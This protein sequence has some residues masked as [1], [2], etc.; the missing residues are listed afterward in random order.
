MKKKSWVV[1]LVAFVCTFL[2]WGCKHNVAVE[3]VFF[4][5]PSNDGV[6]LLVG[7]TYTPEVYFSPLYPT[8]RGY[9]II[10]GDESVVAVRNNSLT[11]LTQGK[12]YIKVVSDEN[13][14]PQK[15]Q[16]KIKNKN[17]D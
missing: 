14:L 2:L 1:C 13:Y 4:N 9:K 12:T 6:V 15:K 7:Q 17:S 11:A 16:K 10:S 8:N 5:A 3:N